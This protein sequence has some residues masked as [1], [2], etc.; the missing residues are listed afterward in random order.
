MCI[1]G[2]ELK[3]GKL[4]VHLSH[5]YLDQNKK[6]EKEAARSTHVYLDRNQKEKRIQDYTQV[7]LNSYFLKRNITINNLNLNCFHE[8]FLEICVGM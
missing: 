5:A 1:L 4:A 3:E 6:G 8:A 7:F 2:S